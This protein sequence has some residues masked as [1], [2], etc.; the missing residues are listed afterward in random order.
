MWVNVVAEHV[1]QQYIILTLV[2][3]GLPHKIFHKSR[4]KL[5]GFTKIYE[6][7]VAIGPR[8][9]HYSTSHQLKQL[10]LRHRAKLTQHCNLVP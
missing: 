2:K 5:C 10:I 1:R 9:H 8:P 6:V 7:L 3:G 4:K